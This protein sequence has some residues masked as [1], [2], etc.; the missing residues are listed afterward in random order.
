MADFVKCTN[1]RCPSRMNCERGA[2]LIERGDSYTCFE[3]QPGK[4]H[5][6]TMYVIIDVNFKPAPKPEPRKKRKKRMGVEFHGR[7]HSIK[8]CDNRNMSVCSDCPDNKKCRRY[9]GKV[10]KLKAKNR[11]GKVKQS[12]GKL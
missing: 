9:Q 2:S 8:H 4:P 1:D 11:G 10:R 6:A 12:R 5:C 7:N 3:V